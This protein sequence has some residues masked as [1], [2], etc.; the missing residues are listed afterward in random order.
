MN[1]MLARG[2]VVVCHD[3]KCARHRL[4]GYVAEGLG[5]AGKQE[6][7]ARRIVSRKVLSAAHAGEH[8]VWLMLLELGALRPVTDQH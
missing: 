5:Q 4:H 2:R 7:I 6:Q 1:E 8:M 3:A